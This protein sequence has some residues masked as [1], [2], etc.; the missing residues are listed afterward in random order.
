MEAEL[1]KMVEAMDKMSAKVSHIAERQNR[2]K[3]E[4][5][6]VI[7]ELKE[8][9]ESNRNHP[10]LGR[11]VPNLDRRHKTYSPT[12]GPFGYVDTTPTGNNHQ[13]SNLRVN[14]GASTSSGVQYSGSMH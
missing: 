6:N 13:P 11:S 2:M 5:D 10:D 1:R 14:A 12:T 3:A 9:I 4:R 7:S 8:S